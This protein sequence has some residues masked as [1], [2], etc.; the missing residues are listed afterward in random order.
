MQETWVQSLGWEDPLEKGKAT[1]SSILAWRIPWREE[2]GGLQSLGSQRVRHDWVTNTC[3][4]KGKQQ[5][6]QQQPLPITSKITRWMGSATHRNH[7]GLCTNR[8][9]QGDKTLAATVSEKNITYYSYLILTSKLWPSQAILKPT[10]FYLSDLEMLIQCKLYN[11]CYKNYAHSCLSE[12]EGSSV[13]ICLLHVH[14][15]WLLLFFPCKGG[16]AGMS[17]V[18]ISRK[19]PLKEKI[20]H[21]LAYSLLTSKMLTRI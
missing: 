17:F 20:F 2:P 8:S 6:Q 9:G 12:A 1:H 3:R 14:L 5:P 4:E 11:P 10:Y 13:N 15:L 16:K 21:T 7:L 18:N 19:K